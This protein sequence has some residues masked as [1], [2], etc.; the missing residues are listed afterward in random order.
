MQIR[1]LSQK[2]VAH[3]DAWPVATWSCV[4]HDFESGTF[5]VVGDRDHVFRLASVSKLASTVAF[6][7]AVTE[8]VFSL[9]YVISQRYSVRDLLGHSS[10]LSTDIDTSVDIFDQQLSREPRSR[11]IYSNTGFEILAR[12]L[13]VESGIEFRDYIEEVLFRGSSMATASISGAA[14]PSAGRTGAAAGMQGTI[15][16]LSSLAVA[17]VDGVPLVDS[18]LLADAKEP[19]LPELPGVLPGFGEMQRNTWGLGIE[20]RGDKRPHW[21]SALNSA[22]T[23]GHFGASGTFLWVDP[24]FNLALGVLT[25]RVFGP[26]AQTLWPELSELVIRTC[27]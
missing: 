8:G 4:V 14:W 1:S 16:D 18:A 5:E 25:D 21:T 7:A 23:F 13:E 6:L 10:G 11:R 26:W 19:Y 17:L 20:V 24:Q 15:F 22:R 3:L 9:D 27:R 2:I 12:F